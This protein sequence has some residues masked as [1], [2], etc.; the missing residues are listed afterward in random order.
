LNIFNTAHTHMKAKGGMP[1]QDVLDVLGNQ[2]TLDP[3]ALQ[4]LQDSG[5]LEG[6]NFDELLNATQKEGGE[7]EKALLEK[8]VKT[9]NEASKSPGQVNPEQLKGEIPLQ[10][11]NPNQAKIQQTLSPE[12]QKLQQEQSLSKVVQTNEPKNVD[13]IQSLLNKKGM[14]TSGSEVI[15]EPTAKILQV[16]KSEHK[17]VRPVNSELSNVLGQKNN[18][19]QVVQNKNIEQIAAKTQPVDLNAQKAKEN[20]LLNFNDFMKK[21]SPTAKANAAKVSY[22]PMKKS[23]FNKKV[24]NSLPAVTTAAVKETKLQDIMFGGAEQNLSQEGNLPQQQTNLK[25]VQAATTTAPVF[26]MSELQ[27]GSPDEVI[28]KIQDYII[29]SKV[30]NEP[31]VQMSFKHDTLG[32]VDLLVQKGAGD[33]VNITIGTN[34]A[35]AAKF[36]NQ[37]QTDLLSTL[38]QAGLRVGDFNLDTSSKSSGQNS[39]QDSANQQFAQGG[40]K[41]HNSESGQRKEEMDKREEL[42]KLMKDK[43]AA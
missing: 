17:A 22:E 38:S 42:W 16:G 29:Q 21:Q 19:D 12:Q 26:N 2:L 18:L 7:E 24:E 23:M 4:L 14:G 15:E 40:Q 28:A 36:F 25:S 5:E 8:L 6:I 33:Q 30:S 39:S 1:S 32:K 27:A 3:A 9:A 35:E 11:A 37:N 41:E 10:Q 31:E 13:S 20:N 34:T 43:E